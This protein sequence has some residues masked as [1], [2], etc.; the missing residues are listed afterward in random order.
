MPWSVYLSSPKLLGPEYDAY[1]DVIASVEDEQ[2]K[3][4]GT[5][6]V[7]VRDVFDFEGF[8]AFRPIWRPA[9]QLIG[10]YMPVEG[11]ADEF[12]LE[13]SD[14]QTNALGTSTLRWLQGAERDAAW[15]R[16]L[17]DW[18]PHEASTLGEG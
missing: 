4:E 2:G 15:Q 16:Y 1:R 18:S 7:Y 17:D 10:W 11:R 6:V 8:R 14:L 13:L 3:V 5:V 12:Y 9:E